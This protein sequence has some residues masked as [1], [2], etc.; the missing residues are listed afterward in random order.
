MNFLK[1]ARMLHYVL[2]SVVVYVLCVCVCVLSAV[3][4][5]GFHQENNRS[6]PYLCHLYRTRAVII[7]QV[8]DHYSYLL[9]GLMLLPFAQLIIIF[10]QCVISIR[11]VIR[12][13]IILSMHISSQLLFVQINH[14]P[15]DRH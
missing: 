2:T 14:S 3:H 12:T 4:G 11:M 7:T 5:F 15:I 6:N 10:G 8:T 1:L 13:V 9:S